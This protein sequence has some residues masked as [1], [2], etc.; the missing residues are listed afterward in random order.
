MDQIVEDT[1]RSSPCEMNFV[2]ESY[3]IFVSR[4]ITHISCIFQLVPGIIIGS[5]NGMKADTINLL[6]SD[7]NV[8][9]DQC[10]EEFMKKQTSHYLCEWLF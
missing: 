7:M 2:P 9:I 10:I 3:K 8:H 4:L 1:W 6:V 5:L